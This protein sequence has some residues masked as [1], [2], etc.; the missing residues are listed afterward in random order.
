MLTLEL[1]D[2]SATP[3]FIEVSRSGVTVLSYDST[4]PTHLNSFGF[5]M[6]AYQPEYM[7]CPIYV[8]NRCHLARLDR[9]GYCDLVTWIPN[10]GEAVHVVS[11]S[12]E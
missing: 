9:I 6:F 4:F 12:S 7:D 3:S 2:Q 5:V 1:P 11:G 10:W 8:G